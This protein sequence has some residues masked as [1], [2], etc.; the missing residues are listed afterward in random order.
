MP[1]LPLQDLQA[2]LQA[3]APLWPELA[4]QHLFLTGGTGFFGSWLTESFLHINRALNLRAHLTVLTRNPAAFRAKAPHLSTDP[5]LSLHLGDIRTFSFPPGLY[6]YVIHAATAASATLTN[7]QPDLQHQ[8]VVQGT[9]RTLAFA[10]QAKTRKL[11]YV[12][13]GALYGPQILPN[14]P[15]DSAVNP[16][17][18]YAR[19]KLEAEHLCRR[20]H[21][22]EI[23]LARPFAFHGPH[24]PLHSHFALGNFLADTLAHRPL[25]L[26]GD[27]RTVRSYLYASDLTIALWTI[28]FRAQPL[29][30]YNLGSEHPISLAA[31]ARTLS[32]QG[33]IEIHGKPTPIQRYVPSTQRLQ[34]ELN[35]HQTV[36]LE[37]G[38]GRTLGWLRLK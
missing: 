4:R 5:T 17:D 19:G 24:L 12:S 27:G 30:P 29:R 28:L 38:L 6:T 13:S 2:I 33:P 9:A 22:M 11:L 18:A 26:R 3:T 32:P 8:T 37:E 31:L 20:A 25:H 10:A 7:T 23:K 1:P 21:T 35:L 34:A 36:S 14:Q 15:E 16:Q